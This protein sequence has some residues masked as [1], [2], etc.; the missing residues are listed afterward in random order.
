MRRLFATLDAKRYSNVRQL[1]LTKTFF[2]TVQT[3]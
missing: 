1:M 2:N 3:P